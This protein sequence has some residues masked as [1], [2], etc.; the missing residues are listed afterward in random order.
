MDQARR[1]QLTLSQQHEDA[2]C[3]AP[4]PQAS[5]ESQKKQSSPKI[6]QKSIVWSGGFEVCGGQLRDRPAE[7][8]GPVARGGSETKLGRALLPRHRRESELDKFAFHPVLPS[9]SLFVWE[10]KESPDGVWRKYNDDE[11]AAIEK[12]YRCGK[13]KLSI[14]GK[15][16]DL[17]AMRQRE[18]GSRSSWTIQ[19]KRRLLEGH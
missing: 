14:D 1:R 9:Q 11:S 3:H 17:T 16:I 10:R 7:Q 5:R 13:E 18:Y 2:H 19:Q 6:S 15:S 4:E 8:N 12:A